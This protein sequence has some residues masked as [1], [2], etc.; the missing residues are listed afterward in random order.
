MKATV[1]DYKQYPSHVFVSGVAGILCGKIILS[2][3]NGEGSPGN[4]F[5]LKNTFGKWVIGDKIHAVC[6]FKTTLI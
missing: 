2:S 5:Q 1:T 6:K 4:P 3:A